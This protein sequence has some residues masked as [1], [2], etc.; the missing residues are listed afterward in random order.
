MPPTKVPTPEK[1]EPMEDRRQP[2]S[3]DTGEQAP[4]EYV[5]P[6]VEDLDTR[7][8]P[9]VTA[10]GRGTVLLSAPRSL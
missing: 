4:T 5:P 6:V 9:A 7:H 10:A 3:P 1:E 8:G 2:E